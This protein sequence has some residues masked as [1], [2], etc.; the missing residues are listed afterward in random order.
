MPPKQKYTDPKLREEVK[1]DIKQSD[2]GGAPGQW[3]ARKAQMMASEYKKRGG[4]Y[5]TPKSDKDKEQ[6]H[7]DKWGEEDWQ[8]KEGEGQAKQSDGSRKRYLPKKAWEQMDDGE[9]EATDQKKQKASKQGKQ[10]VGNTDR[11]R[12]ARKDANEQEEE[13]YEGRNG[14][15]GAN[16]DD[17]KDDE[18]EEQ[19]EEEEEKEKEMKGTKPQ[20]KANAGR[21]RGRPQK[22]EDKQQ[23]EAPAHK[24][25]KKSATTAGVNRGQDSSKDKKDGGSQSQSG[26][27]VGSRK[28]NAEAPAKQA[29]LQRLPK[30][31]TKAYWKAMPGWVDGDVVEVLKKGKS[32]DGKQVKASKD[33]P[34]VVLKSSSS[35]KICV[36]KVDNVYFD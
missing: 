20:Q 17:E 13:D 22:E 28:D 23:E 18:G 24:A 26:K 21:K 5:T 16:E 11:A 27:T 6:K 30:K 9:K 33:D 3:S 4:D 12:R 8:T 34:K 15:E 19:E 36:H 10:F 7:L 2:K 29:S 35:G 14:G 1:E 25:Q 31:G 32:V